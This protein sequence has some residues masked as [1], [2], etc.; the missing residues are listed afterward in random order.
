[1]AV[2]VFVALPGAASRL[3]LG[4][5]SLVFVGLFAMAWDG[6]H[7]MFTR[8]GIEIRTLGFRLKSIPLGE[9]KQYAVTNWSPIC[10]YGIRGIGNRKAYVWGNS[11]VRIQ[12][13]D[14]EFFLGHKEPQRVIQDLDLIKQY[15]HS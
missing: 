13:K 4:I 15:S 5:L 2:L 12:T 3:G 11:G 6:F 8:H 14:G 7:Y 9:I 10:G 1:V